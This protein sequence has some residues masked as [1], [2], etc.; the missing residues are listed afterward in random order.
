[1]HNR[2]LCIAVLVTVAVL[3]GSIAQADLVGDIAGQISEADYRNY[4]DTVLYAQTGDDRGA[5]AEHDL[6]QTAIYD[7]FNGMG[8]TTVLDPFDIDV[9]DGTTHYDG[10]YYNVV[11]ELT[12]TTRPDDIYIIGAHYDS[13]SNPGAD[14]NASGVAGILEAARVL[15]QYE[16]DATI[17]FICFDREEQGSYGAEAYVIEHLEDNIIGMLNLDMIAYNPSGDHYNEAYLYSTPASDPL[18]LGFQ[19]SLATYGGITAYMPEDVPYADHAMFEDYGFAATTLIEYSWDTNPYYHTLSDAVNMTD[20]IDY[21]YATNMTRGAAA[22]LADN[23]GHTPEPATWLLLAA[24]MGI[25]ALRR[26]KLAK[27]AA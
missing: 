15:S 23:A 17:R 12:G 6:T 16:F 18:R 21:T 24:G 13:V 9:W 1:M 11:G 2:H 26:R 19:N 4:L 5:G 20:Y 22:Y 8:L 25:T 7:A 3:T 10:T 27:D 14:D